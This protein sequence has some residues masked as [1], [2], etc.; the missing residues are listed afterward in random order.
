LKSRHNELS[1]KTTRL[2]STGL[3]SPSSS[4]STTCWQ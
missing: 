4:M 1:V 3:D 2:D